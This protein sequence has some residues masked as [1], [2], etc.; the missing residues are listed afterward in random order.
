MNNIMLKLDDLFYPMSDLG[1]VFS[2]IY[3]SLHSN[4]EDF[5]EVASAFNQVFKTS[6]SSLDIKNCFYKFKH[7][8]N[9]DLALFK[10]TYS[11][12]KTIKKDFCKSLVPP[13]SYCLNCNS[14]LEKSFKVK[15]TTFYIRKASLNLIESLICKKCFYTYSADT[16]T[17]NTGNTYLYPQST[18]ISILITSS[19]TSFQKDLLVAY[20]GNLIRNGVSL[21]GF[22]DT[23]NTLYSSNKMNRD[24]DRRRLSEAWLT[25]KLRDY[26]YIDEVF[27]KKGQYFNP[28]LIESFLSESFHLIKKYVVLNCFKQHQSYCKSSNCCKIGKIISYTL[29]GTFINII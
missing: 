17:D 29:Q 13:I 8:C 5:V 22:C 26:V 15:S 18:E 14:Y 25:F 23:Y 20:D 12:L 28:K 16:Y 24:L 4:Q 7:L 6:Y 10:N 9:F 21:E 11:Q 3:L 2:L 19:K 1:Q 27:S